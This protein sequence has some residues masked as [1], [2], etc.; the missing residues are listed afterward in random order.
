[1]IV[2]T[3]TDPAG[4]LDTVLRQ[5]LPELSRTACRAAIAAGLVRVNGRVARK[6]QRVGN[7]DRIEVDEAA[8]ARPAVPPVDVPILFLDDALIALDKPAGLPAAARRPGTRPSLAGFLLARFPALGSVGASPLEAGLLHRLDTGTSGV[9]LAARTA[10]AWRAVREQFRRREV[11]K[12]YLAIVH[13]HLR[14]PHALSHRLAHAPR[15]PGRMT[16]VQERAKPSRRLPR[17]SWPAEATVT[18]LGSA[19]STTLVQVELRTGVTHQIR[20]QLAAVGHPIAGD[21][22]YGGESFS[23]LLPGRHL[24]H[25][26]RLILRHPV[27]GDVRRIRSPLPTD[28]RRTLSEIGYDER[29]LLRGAS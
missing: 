4:R 19:R 21:L 20:V 29:T 8:R 9:I 27:R 14:A 25:A 3:A 26:V 28:F 17:H 11:Q 6:G 15:P 2:L 16:V 24:L 12:S 1:V 7:G 13:G 23:G 10:A 5:R 22:T 18:P